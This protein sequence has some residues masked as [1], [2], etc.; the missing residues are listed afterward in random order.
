MASTIGSNIG[1]VQLLKRLKCV[2]PRTPRQLATYI[3]VFL[4]LDVPSTRLCPNHD[5]PF[6]YL[7][8]SF[9]GSDHVRRSALSAT[10]RQS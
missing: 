5:S 6:D 7:T 8:F 2:R 1:A 4:G 9:L 10:P 3:K